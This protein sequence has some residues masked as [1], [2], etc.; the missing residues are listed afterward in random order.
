[1]QPIHSREQASRLRLRPDILGCD[2]KTIG[3]CNTTG[4]ENINLLY[5]DYNSSRHGVKGD[6]HISVSIVVLLEVSGS[7]EYC[8][9]IVIPRQRE[10]VRNLNSRK[11]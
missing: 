9:G 1:M 8:L 6:D 10:L 2:D 4:I 7:G 5:E 3:K 11:C